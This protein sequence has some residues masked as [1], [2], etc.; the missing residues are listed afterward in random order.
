MSRTW[1]QAASRTAGVTAPADQLKWAQEALAVV[2]ASSQADA[3]KWEASIRNNV[4]YALH[5]QGRY[6]EALDQFALA[7]ACRERAGVAEPIRVA[8]WMVAWTLRALDR[9]DEALDMQLRL[10]RQCAAAGA[11][12]MKS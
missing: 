11:P 10:E 9:L 8:R 12:L 3:K 6:A 1:P 7:L 2:E 5:Q 4:G